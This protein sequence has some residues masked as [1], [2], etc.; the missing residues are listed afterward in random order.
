MLFDCLSFPTNQF[1]LDMFFSHL[2]WDPKSSSNKLFSQQIIPC[3]TTQRISF[4][5]PFIPIKL[6]EVVPVNIVYPI[7]KRYV[8]PSDSHTNSAS[9]LG[10]A[11]C[12]MILGHQ[13]VPNIF[14]LC[15]TSFMLNSYRNIFTKDSIK[16]NYWRK[17]FS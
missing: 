9:Q 7:V 4:L 6:S 10:L 14:F 15:C 17:V 16:Q 1:L 12:H 13:R 3:Q 11:Y 2:P 5:F 8:S